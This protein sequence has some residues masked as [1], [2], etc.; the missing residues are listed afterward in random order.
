[1]VECVIRRC[2]EPF[3]Y[4][5]YWFCAIQKELLSPPRAI[6]TP[7]ELLLLTRIFA[8]Q[9]RYDEIV[10]LLNSEHLGV[11]SRLVQNDWSFVTTKLDA[12][13]KTEQWEEGLAYAREL[14]GLPDDPDAA[15]D[16]K[17]REKDD[18]KVWGLLLTAAK[19]LGKAEYAQFPPPI[20]NR[21]L[22]TYTERLNR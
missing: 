10:K 22:M 8:T 18:W 7:E 4:H 3:P 20:D 5:L 14:L 6:Q 11:S 2:E 12:L 1:M 13:E 15:A 16:M 21:R 9:S 19:K 17:Y